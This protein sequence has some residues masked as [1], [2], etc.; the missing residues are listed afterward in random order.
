MLCAKCQKNVATMHITNVVDGT[1]EETLHVCKDCVPPE[2]LAIG[3]R[4]EFCGRDAFSGEMRPGGVMI[5]WCYD[6]Q[7]ERVAILKKLLLSA[8]LQGWSASA[9]AS[10]SEE[11]TQM[12]KERRQQD[13]RDKG[14]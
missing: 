2:G 12:L 1:E 8:G 14:S 7:L 13:G 5:Y 10:A 11:A 9:S 4:C 3:K 6:C